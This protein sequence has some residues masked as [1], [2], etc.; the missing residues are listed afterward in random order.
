MKLSP[1][2]KRCFAKGEEICRDV[3][4]KL[5]WLEQ[6]AKA[7]PQYAE[8]V[9]ELRDLHDHLATVCAAGLAACSSPAAQ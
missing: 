5:E 9:G 4:P 8:Q 6:V 3:L 2:Q 1:S 7:A